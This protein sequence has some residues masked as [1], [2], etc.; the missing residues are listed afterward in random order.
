MPTPLFRPSLWESCL[1]GFILRGCCR[2][3]LHPEPHFS[4]PGQGTPKVTVMVVLG[5]QMSGAALGSLSITQCVAR[6]HP[7]PRAL[8]GYHGDHFPAERPPR[9]PGMLGKLKS[10]RGKVS[11]A[12]AKKKII[13]ISPFGGKGCHLY[14]GGRAAPLKFKQKIKKAKA[15]A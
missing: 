14:A 7:S 12:T 11:M 5:T 9:W 8:A 10:S 15:G 4:P 3:L 13:Y 1:E 6:S 2:D